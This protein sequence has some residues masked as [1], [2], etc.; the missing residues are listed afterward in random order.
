MLTDPWPTD[1]DALVDL[2]RRLGA[3]GP[4][5]WQPEGPVSTVGASYVC[6]E[7]GSRGPGRVGENGWAAAAHKQRGSRAET[8][9]VAGNAPAAYRPGLLAL[10]E[11]A[12]RAAAVAGL[13]RLPAVLLIDATGRDHP[14]R[15]GLAVHLGAVFDVPTVGVTRRPLCATGDPPSEQRYGATSPLVLGGQVVGYWVRSRAEVRPL[16]VHAAWR[17]APP[18][19]VDVVLA[20]ARRARTPQPL[21]EARRAARHARGRAGG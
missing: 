17:T 3:A 21:R 7:R 9:V 15:A 1:A 6:F 2:Q 5:R 8:L 11:G 19:A 13:P 18:V 4:A 12:L 14:R 16:A 10:R 20:T